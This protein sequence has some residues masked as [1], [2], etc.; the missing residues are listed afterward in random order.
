MYL[1]VVGRF[2]TLIVPDGREKGTYQSRLYKIDSHHLYIGIPRTSES[3]AAQALP[4]GTNVVLDYQDAH[5]IPCQFATVVDDVANESF[6]RL[7]VLKCPQVIE[8][9]QRRENV[10]IPVSWPL[11][12]GT[13]AYGEFAARMNDLS[14]GGASAWIPESIK[15]SPGDTV[16]VRFTVPSGKRQLAVRTDA[17]VVCAFAN[18]EP[19]RNRYLC[20]FHFTSLEEELRQAIVEYV[21]E[22]QK[23]DVALRHVGQT[24][25]F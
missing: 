24:F 11:M 23:L 21:F 14:G 2:F 20:S 25:V 8:R 17:E 10:R 19:E 3:A 9:H 4:P 5:D 6:N 16:E 12:C 22:R 7:L 1:P 18:D 15:L 13:P